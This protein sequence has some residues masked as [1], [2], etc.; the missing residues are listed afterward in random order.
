M[1]RICDTGKLRE[2]P[3]RLP[4]LA[5]DF[6]T[7]P[8]LVPQEIATQLNFCLEK[9][10]SARPSMSTMAELIGQHLLRD[11]HRALLVSG[12]STYVLNNKKR[13]VQLSVAGRG[14][15]DISY[16][17]LRFV[18]TALSGDV[19]VSRIIPEQAIEDVQ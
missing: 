4:C 9:D 17:G 1:T 8:T 11:R 19:A 10:V 13:V 14:A 6:L 7:F 5:A 2:M 3:P 15:I 18:L 16:D 12:G